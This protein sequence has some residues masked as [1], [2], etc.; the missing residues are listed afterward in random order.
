M[1]SCLPGDAA[2]WPSL[3]SLLLAQVL[4]RLPKRS[5]G[6]QTERAEKVL[7][8]MACVGERVSYDN[9]VNALWEKIVVECRVR[10]KQL[11][12]LAFAIFPR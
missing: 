3:D 7:Q 4:I 9:R 10:A 12:F 2:L 11:S 5:M 6:M 1:I 8:F